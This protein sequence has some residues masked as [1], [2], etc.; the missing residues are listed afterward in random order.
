MWLTLQQVGTALKRD[1]WR[2]CSIQG[3]NSST[4]PLGLHEEK[5]F[6]TCIKNNNFNLHAT[7]LQ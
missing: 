3:C 1:C 6:K 2:V 7:T 5:R 4:L